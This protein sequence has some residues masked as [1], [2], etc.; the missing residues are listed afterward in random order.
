M[1]GTTG[2]TAGAAIRRPDQAGVD[3]LGTVVPARLLAKDFATPLHAAG[4][5]GNVVAFRRPRRDG[6]HADAPAVEAGTEARPAPFAASLSHP[7]RAIALIALSVAAHAAV[8]LALH[9]EPA[10]FASIGEVVISAD[11]VLGADSAA[12]L[13]RQPS[14]DEAQSAAAPSPEAATPPAAEPAPPEPA[15][16]PPPADVATAAD[17]RPDPAPPE[18]AAPQP[19]PLEPE[20]VAEIAAAPAPRPETRAEPEPA[21]PPTVTRAAP[22]KARPT[23]PAKE[24][25][26]NR[27]KDASQRS[28]ALPSPAA[29]RGSGVGR[30]DAIANYHGRIAAHLARH[31]QY[32]AGARGRGQEG[33][34]SVT[35]GLDGSGH[36]TSVRLA[37]ASGVADFDQEAVAMVRRAS[38]FP[39]P[40]TGRPMSFTVPVS[41][42]LR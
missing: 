24:R 35:F 33:G 8:V 40:P 14:A 36:V 23:E 39:A 31:K 3:P 11:L 20:P 10:P 17:V 19:E 6:V 9:H 15:R 30:S 12:G 38:P 28:A 25:A 4:D 42:R 2:N 18:A 13:A 27:A 32:P 26:K 41:F 1:D 22:A 16:E 37:R 7:A 21:R 5:L 29:A 34:A